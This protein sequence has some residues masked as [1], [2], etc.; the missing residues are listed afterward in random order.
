MAFLGS[1]SRHEELYGMR[2]SRR[3]TTHRSKVHPSVALG[4]VSL[5]ALTGSLAFGFQDENAIGRMSDR[6]DTLERDN[7]LLREEVQVLRGEEQADWLTEERSTEIRSLVNDVLADSANRTSLQE[8][9]AMA[10]WSSDLGFY[11]RSADNR[12]LLQVGGLL[13]ARYIWSTT[14]DAGFTNAG[15]QGNPVQI[16]NDAYGFDLPHSRLVFKGHVFEPGIRYFIRTEFTPTGTRVPVG[17]AVNTIDSFGGLNLL[18][19]YV[20]FDLD[21]Q[22]SVRFGQFKLPFSRER[23][24][25][26]QNLMAAD[27]SSVDEL[28][29]IGRSQG[30]ELSMQGNDLS[31]AF[32]FSDG[33]TDNLLAG[34]SNNSRYYPAGTNPLNSPYWD[35]QASFAFTSRLEYKISGDWSEFSEMTSP[36]GEQNG[37]MLGLA[38]HYQMGSA[39]SDLPTSANTN[40]GYFGGGNNEWINVT[41]DATFNFGGASIFAALYYSNSETKWSQNDGSN[42]L[43]GSTLR[44]TTNLLGL[45]LQ[46]SMYVAPKWE[47]F[48]RYQYIDPITQPEISPFQDPGGLPYPTPSFS[49][50]SIS[51]LGANWYIDGQ[52]LRWSF[53]MSYSNN[54]ITDISATNNNGFRPLGGATNEFVILTQFQM[55]F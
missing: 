44:G 24:V 8:S 6:L 29:G 54:E 1:P 34:N 4:A 43:G 14:S 16:P 15:P 32:A 39:P 19:A 38:G 48:A 42:G 25:S 26:V 12:F 10:G 11:L 9:A 47:L 36:I 37:I 3:N 22:W 30:I 46:G 45:V 7:A 50:L 27:R 35:Q 17:Q 20:A 41:A 51:T 28:M 55:Q 49:P 23:L 33:G 18:D 21:N 5:A 40:R 13:Q 31:W 53:Q 52:D 2:T